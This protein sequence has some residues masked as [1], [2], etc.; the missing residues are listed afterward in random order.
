[1]ETK[2]N[3]GAIFKN[4]KVKDSQPD[5]RGKIVVENKEYEIALWLKEAKTGVKYF[6]ASLQEPRQNN[7]QVNNNQHMSETMGDAI[8]KSYDDLPF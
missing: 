3:S 6:S 1:M 2:N 5:Y 4:N 7:N 8:A